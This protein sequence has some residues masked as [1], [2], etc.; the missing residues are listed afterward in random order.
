MCAV[1]TTFGYATQARTAMLPAKSDSIGISGHQNEYRSGVR[2]ANWVEEQFGV[3]GAN[4]S[5]V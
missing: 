1:K 5:K 4:A 2:I 3:E